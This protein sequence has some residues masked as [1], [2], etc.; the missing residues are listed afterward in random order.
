MTLPGP[1]IVIAHETDVPPYEQLRRIVIERV[2][3]GELRAG[4]KIPTVRALAGQL[5]LAPNT[6]ARAYRELEQLGVLETRGRQGTFVAATGDPTMDRA[7]R[8]AAS[9]VETVRELGISNDDALKLV[10]AA[11][12]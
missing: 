9:Y 6:V 3:T 11:L 12:R 1:P 5:G 2:R 7:A 8:A 10:A 4:N